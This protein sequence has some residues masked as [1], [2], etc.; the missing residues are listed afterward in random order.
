MKPC[1]HVIDDDPAH[2]DSMRLFLTSVDLEV[3]CYAAAQEFLAISNSIF[4]PGCILLDLRMP[5]MSGLELQRLSSERYW[6]LPIIFLSGHANVEATVRAM[7]HGAADFL[8]KPAN[9]EV[10]LEKINRAIERSQRQREEYNHHATVQA[11]MDLLT[12]RERQV[13]DGVFEGF[14]NKEIA[15]QL[16]ISHKTVEL[17]RSN[18]MAKMHADSLAQLVRMRMQMEAVTE[19]G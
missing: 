15:R 10:L 19:I 17:H 11:R 13:L 8:T 9:P 3:A 7:H 12:P 5:Q 14:S 16:Q 4:Q 18:L 6:Y 1:I 2:R